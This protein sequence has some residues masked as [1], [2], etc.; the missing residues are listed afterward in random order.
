MKR[1]IILLVTLFT[2]PIWGQQAITLEECYELAITNYPL[3]KQSELLQA[4]TQLD[5]DAISTAKLPQF[6]L[7]AQ[8]TYQS[9]VIEV[10]IPNSTIETLNKDQ[11]R[12]TLSVNQL[13]YN[14]GTTEASLNLK[15]A[16]LKTKQKQVEVSLNE[17]KQQINQ[18]YFSV[19]LQV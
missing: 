15:T 11:Y 14:G 16:Q 2:L 9:D 17:L 3:A 4:Q 12:A 5:K 19:L 8:A 13:I 18:L 6:S 10:P 7:E 1:Y